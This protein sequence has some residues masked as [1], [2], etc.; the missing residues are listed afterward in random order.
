MAEVER[1]YV[2]PE[3]RGHGIAAALL[4]ALEAEASALF[5]DR[6]VLR[7]GE[8]QPEAMAL[9]RRAGYAEIERFGEYTD[10]PLSVCMCKTLA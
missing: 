6:M 9:Y 3:A 7:T 5:A 10:S 2:R 1:L 4:G 8:W